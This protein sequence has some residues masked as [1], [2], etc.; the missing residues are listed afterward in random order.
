MRPQKPPKRDATKSPVRVATGFT[1]ARC[2]RQS[3]HKIAE[4]EARRC[5]EQLSGRWVGAAREPDC[6]KTG[7]GC[8]RGEP[9]EQAGNPSI[10][11]VE[12]DGP[13]AVG[14]KR[15]QDEQRKRRANHPVDCRARLDPDPLEKTKCKQCHGESSGK[16]NA[17]PNG[18][19][20]HA[21]IPLGRQK[22][23]HSLVLP[24]P[25]QATF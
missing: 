23:R 7:K 19:V 8:G 9:A 3:K 10:R 20:E 5:T 6:D 14:H 24:Q 17:G 21:D 13:S 18:R 4:Q 1:E 12:I 11:E 25:L 22:P 16:R 15:Y 2:D